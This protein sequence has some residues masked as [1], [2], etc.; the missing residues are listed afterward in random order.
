MECA[1]ETSVI[2]KM[3]Q[4][5]KEA[6][7]LLEEAVEKSNII[8]LHAKDNAQKLLQKTKEDLQRKQESLQKRLMSEGEKEAA[9]IMAKKEEYLKE[10]KTRAVQYRTQ[11]LDEL[12]N[13]LMEEL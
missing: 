12:W 3:L 6:C 4:T 11:A 2:G 8:V 9:Q 7:R 1:R 13:R 10:L 5:D